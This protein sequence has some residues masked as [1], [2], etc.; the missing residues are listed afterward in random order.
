MY[1]PEISAVAIDGLNGTGVSASVC[2]FIENALTPAANV[3]KPSTRLSGNASRL[4]D[5]CCACDLRDMSMTGTVSEKHA[6]R[7]IAAVDR[8]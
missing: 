7:L 8:G 3:Y 4:T 1:K 6:S 5:K 2:E